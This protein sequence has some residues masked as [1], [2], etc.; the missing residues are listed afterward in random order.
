MALRD[1]PRTARHCMVAVGISLA[2]A[3]GA[4]TAYDALNTPLTLGAARI[5]IAGTSNVH[6]YTASTTAIKVTRVQLNAN[7]AGPTFWDEIVKP[8]A[9]EAFEIAIPAATLS[10]PKKDL[11]KN[12]LKAL[13]VT[14]HQEITFRLSRLEP[15]PGTP[16]ALRGIGMLQVAGVEREVTVDLTTK[17]GS[18]GLEVHGELQLL[19]TDFGIAPPK[20][21]LGMLKTDP[22]VTVTFDTVV[23]VPST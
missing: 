16:G 1:F 19:M 5:T 2:A 22:K 17:R 15:R 13:K 20:A 12:M 21:M 23:A 6:E 7:V 8:G 10:S 9:I 3:T 14:E 4:V 18:A 11:D